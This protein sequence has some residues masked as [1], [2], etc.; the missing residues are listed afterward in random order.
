M[1]TAQTN[2]S[3]PD[4]LHDPRVLRR[5]RRWLRSIAWRLRLLLVVRALL[6]C[7]GVA[8]FGLL[9]IGLADYLLRL[10]ALLRLVLL[11]GLGVAI[12]RLCL[13]RLLPAWRSLLSEPDVALLVEKHD[14][15][16]RG[17]LA[18]AVDLDRADQ[19]NAFADN[20]ISD[21][22]RGAA[23]RTAAHRLA[24]FRPSRVL[25]PSTLGMPGLRAAV[26][27]GVLL[28][29]AMLSPQLMRVGAQRVLMPWG[30]VRWPVR[31]AIEDITGAGPHAIDA[32]L[33]IRALIGNA[34][35]ELDDTTRALVNWR[36]V[37]ESGDAIGDWSR[38]LLMPQRRRGAARDI[39]VYEQLIDARE[40]AARRPEQQRFTLEYRI[41]TRDDQ[42]R[43][44]AVTLVRP[45]ELRSTRVELEL[46]AY[47]RPIVARD[48]VASGTIETDTG[49]T[50]IA[51]VLR[52]TRVAIEWTFSKPVAEQDTQPE[53]VREVA[54]LGDLIAYSRDDEGRVRLELMAT[55][56]MLIE[57]VIRDRAGIPVRSTITAA[58]EVLDDLR[59]SVQIVEPSRDEHLAPGAEIELG[60]ELVD[61]L[62]LTRGAIMARVARM[63]GGSEG[64]PPEPEAEPM[65]LVREW[66]DNEPW[67]AIN[68]TLDLRT[69]DLMSGDELRV[70]ASAWDLR[71]S[72]K[73]TEIGRG[74]SG[75]RVF[76]IVAAEELIEQVRRALDPLRNTLRSLD[77]RQGQVQRLV[78]DQSPRSAEE[79]RALSERLRA[80]QNAVAQLEQS[81]ERN[82]ID[83]GALQD[84][85]ADAARLLEEAAQ[86]SERAD[87][88]IRRG[89]A[90]AAESSQRR[91]RDRLGELLSMLDQ[92]Q[93]AWMALRNV[94][95]LRSDLE[96]I[97]DETQ[98]LSQRTA[99]QS[100]DELSPED[101][102]ALERILDRQ[103]QNA[104]DAREAI[105]TLDER[106]GQ[107]EENDPTQAEALRR[108]AREAR[109][110]Q[111]EEKLREAGAQISRNQ[112][113]SANQNQEQ[114]LDDL[115]QMLEELENTIQNRDN[116]LRRELASIIDSI[117]QLI[118]AQEREIIRLDSAMQMDDLTGTDARIIALVGNTLSVRDEALG[119]FPETRVIAEHIGRAANAQN[120]A[121]SVLRANPPDANSA[122]QSQRGALQHLR[123]ALEEAQR[124]DEQA[125]QRQ[126]QQAR[127]EL[128]Q[129]YER[130]LDTQTRIHD[131]SLA[132]GRDDLDRRQRAQAR[133]VAQSQDELR[134]ELL[135]MDDQHE[136]LAEAPVFNLAHRQLERLMDQSGAGLTERRIT[137]RTTEAQRRAMS[138]L[139]S[140]VEVLQDQ[141]QQQQEDF[142]DG[143]S[144]GGEGGGE[145]SGEQPVIPPVAELKLLRSMQQL[146]A[147][148]TRSISE[149]GESTE[150]E[151]RSLAD[152]QKQ[153]FEQGAALIER[154]NPQ[155]SPD[156]P[157]EGQDAPNREPISPVQDDGSTP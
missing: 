41:A 28:L 47:A 115:E 34:E 117:E 127:N 60:A 13:S 150:G 135:A 84:T 74:E 39:P 123:N 122:Q 128:R 111:L 89:S 16:T 147:E 108:A 125:A 48:I 52:G 68:T 38:T 151:I 22:L 49:D 33:A 65:T 36:L 91:V 63:P 136:G 105:N 24:Q 85:L 12:G 67:A 23:L 112:T 10:P 40:R 58:L 19:H 109:A 29:I 93:D 153:L 113:G 4:D 77:E 152:L 157:G 26:P 129:Q 114:V 137:P 25:R 118:D 46:P 92:G 32:P 130:M 72:D 54:R 144:G 35:S 155:P 142:E 98:R 124:L 99:G 21:A 101:R 11:I 71:I 94:Q 102:S 7:L 55:E 15:Q 80:N 79:Q 6:V 156:N 31:Y 90:D 8:L 18:S 141:Q 59:P 143:S 154:M 64:A 61:D 132:L 9:L 86:Q 104:E 62:G 78:R 5:V 100:L 95:Q 30:D 43:T 56:S 134:E 42:S 27:L 131:E 110:A 50:S 81:V 37:D 44:R 133:A 88:Q 140:L 73:D 119:A 1:T 107:L 57:P 149:L 3:R 75:V 14:P 82:R 45:P 148:Q 17:I 2:P 76:R 51:P 116:A 69:L 20:T 106:A 70:W 145:G 103:M 126:T 139:A 146:V 83:D 66:I 138:V 121:I 87:D 97:R 53:W 96:S 120:S